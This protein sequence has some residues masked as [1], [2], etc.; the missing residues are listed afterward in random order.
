MFFATRH[1]MAARVFGVALSYIVA[2]RSML[3][4]GKARFQARYGYFSHVSR[5]C[6]PIAGL[7][8]GPFIFRRKRMQVSKL[9]DTASYHSAIILFSYIILQFLLAAS[10]PDKANDNIY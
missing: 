6:V 8:A 1:A 7:A 5:R 9:M 2:K 4:N 3:L 10:S